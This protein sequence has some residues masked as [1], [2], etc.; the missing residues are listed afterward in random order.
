LK[1]DAFQDNKKT[2][3]VFDEPVLHGGCLPPGSIFLDPT[4]P[5]RSRKGLISAGMSLGS[6]FITVDSK[7]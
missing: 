6:L 1:N 2:C 4:K 7:K 5:W 3:G